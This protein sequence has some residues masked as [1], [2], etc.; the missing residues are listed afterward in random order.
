MNTPHIIASFWLLQR[1]EKVDFDNFLPAFQL[2]S[3]RS[4]FSEV[5]R[6]SVL[7]YVWVEAG[8]PPSRFYRSLAHK[9]LVAF[10][11][12]RD[13]WHSAGNWFR[14]PC[15][16]VRPKDVSRR[17]LSEQTFKE[18]KVS[19]KL[20]GQGRWPNWKQETS[21][22]P[23]LLHPSLSPSPISHLHSRVQR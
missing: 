11:G 6:H 20:S 5:L 21:P 9:C 14:W 17:K 4:R 13:W 1:Y 23:G 7:R 12:H 8:H 3:W 22:V 2:I 19:K 18:P 10:P 16:E 15:S